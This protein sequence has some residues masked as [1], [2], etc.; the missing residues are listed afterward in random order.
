VSKKKRHAQDTGSDPLAGS[1]RDLWAALANGDLLQAEREFGRCATFP[2]LLGASVDEAHRILIGMAKESGTPEDAALLRLIML[3][4]SPAVK[5]QARDALGQL[6]AQGVYAAGWVTEAGKAEPV[7]ASR[8][9]DVFGDW[10]Q[11]Y[12]TYRYSAGEHTLVARVDLTALPVANRLGLVDGAPDISTDGPFE[13]VEEISLEDARAH[14]DAAL[15]DEESSYYYR[16]PELAALLP[17]ARSRLRRLPAGDG[18]ARTPA[19][20]SEDRAALVR[21]FLASDHAAQ[22]VAANAAATRFWA[23]ILT[24]WSSRVP[25]HPPLQAGPRTLFYLIDDYVPLTYPVTAEQRQHMA[26]AVTAW[27]R[28]SAARRGLDEEH[29][30]SDLARPLDAFPVIYDQDDYAAERRSYLA[31]V[32]TADMDVTGLRDIWNVRTVAM[33]PSEDREEYGGGLEDLDATDPGDRARFLAAEFAECKVPAGLSRDAFLGVV[34]QVADELWQG[35]PPSTRAQALA[36]LAE[37][38]MDRHDIMHAL[39]RH[40]LA[41]RN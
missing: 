29:M 7:R 8:W 40:A 31:D 6:T 16:R 17:L 24:A 25:G 15:K 27:A 3:A 2:Q 28:W 18:S 37:G 14:L 38:E 34:R 20:T 19:Y 32:A 22:A 1:I 13:A 21:E 36:L 35:E 33:P 41:H 39:V 12:I 4:G 10:E 23:E 30:I 11:L 9:Y 26:A 5:Q